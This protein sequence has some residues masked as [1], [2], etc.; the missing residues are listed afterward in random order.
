MPTLTRSGL[1]PIQEHSLTSPAS[2]QTLSLTGGVFLFVSVLFPLGRQRL[3]T[4]RP[5]RAATW[6][7]RQ[8]PDPGKTFN[9]SKDLGLYPQGNG[10]LSK[11]FKQGS[12]KEHSG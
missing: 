5:G 7:G 4:C 9:Y 10:D 8:G 3:S 6:G 12:A 11:A 1:V 2:L